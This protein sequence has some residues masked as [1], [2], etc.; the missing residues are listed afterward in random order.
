MNAIRIS[1]LAKELEVKSKL[2]LDYLPEIGVTDKKTHSHNLDEDVANKVRQHFRSLSQEQTAEAR[3]P[4]PAPPP[5]A[6]A[7]ASPVARP[8][9]GQPAS[10][11]AVTAPVA[12]TKE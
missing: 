7:P 4:E 11:A 2:I 8:L 6:K 3:A 10:Q 12:A 1:D 5:P 9:T